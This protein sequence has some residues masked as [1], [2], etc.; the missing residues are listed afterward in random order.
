[1]NPTAHREDT[2]LKAFLGR[3]LRA[4]PLVVAAG[5]VLLALVVLVMVAVQPRYAGTTS[6]VIKAPMRHDD[7][8]RLVQPQEPLPR[9]D[10]S[11]YFNEQVRITSEPILRN[12]VDRLGLRTTYVERGT[13]VDWDVYGQNPIAVELDTTSVED[14]AHVPYGVTFY[15]QQVQGDEFT[16]VGDGKYGPEKRTIEVDLPGRF[17][18]W[19]TLDSMRVRIT[20]VPGMEA[21]LEGETA[22]SYGFI[23]RDPRQVTLDLMGAVLG[24]TSLAEATTVNITYTGAPKAKVLDVLNAV[25]EEYVKDHLATQREQLDKTITMVQQEIARNAAALNSSS[26]KLEKF[27]SQANITNMQHSTILLQETHRELDERKESLKV[28]LDYYTNLVRML[29]TRNEAKPAS[30]KAFGITDPL[31]ND[32][33]TNFAKLQTDIAMMEA[34]GKTANPSYNRMVRLL[35][36]QR[37]NILSSVESFKQNTRLS[38]QNVDSQRQDILARQSAVPKLDRDLMDKEREQRT[39]ESVNA[40]LMARL[41]SLNVQRAVLTP[42]VSVA[43]PA[44]L[45]N[46][47]PSFPNAVIL[48]AVAFMLALLAPLGFLIAKALTSAKITG[49]KD[50]AAAL[51]EV[52]VVARIPFATRRDPADFIKHAN[53][54]AY[55]ETAKLAALLEQGRGRA[56]EMY[57]MCGADGPEDVGP[58]TARLAWV[59]AAR[60]NRVLLAADGEVP[61]IR[62]E[63]PPSLTVMNGRGAALDAIRSGAEE[64]GVDM[65]LVQGTR[66][67]DLVITPRL[68]L[69]DRALVLCQ[70][71]ITTH[72]ALDN[73][74]MARANG[75]LPPLAFIMAGLMEDHLPGC[76]L[77]SR[78]G[79]RALGLWGALRYQWQRAVR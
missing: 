30:P 32:M 17:G 74:A 14:L 18:E 72:D 29:S 1:M 47:D 53:S 40:D 71:G 8:T 68:A 54:R 51:P 60:G 16:L 15:L 4:W 6:I 66:V 48:L 28:Q 7:P 34:E 63:R 58:T 26:D 55:M 49:T 33:T 65:V 12:V 75:Q 3:Y 62:G 67:D 41:S 77:L 46:L 56:P 31:L 73:L 59:L 52:P 43:A 35:E 21:Q 39:Y 70:P 20:R 25:G 42:E 10:K 22:K 78:R 23:Q 76:G 79:E 37:G 36:E 57:L 69:C 2:D 27:K 38:L 11:Y 9:T 19:I 24:S 45:T 61:A 44:Y 50:L 64:L 5:A 13:L